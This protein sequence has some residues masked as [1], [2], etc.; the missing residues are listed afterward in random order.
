MRPPL[1]AV[2][3]LFG[4]PT[5]V[6]NV[7]SLATVPVILARGA[8]FYREYGVGQSRGT[9]PVQLAGNLRRGGL[10]ELAFGDR[11][12]IAHRRGNAKQQ[13]SLW[14]SYLRR[15]PTG[16]LADDARAGLCRHAPPPRRAGC[17]REY[18]RDFPGGAY[19]E[20]ARRE[21]GPGAP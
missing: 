17:W 7:V 20:Q 18:L 2:K 6:N 10:V 21:A 4:M 5:V 3:G 15:F 1:P 8:A 19:S 11:F 14:K 13:V 9:L 12:T 16:R